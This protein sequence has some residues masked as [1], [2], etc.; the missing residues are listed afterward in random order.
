MYI[1]KRLVSLTLPAQLP[2]AAPDP[3]RTVPDPGEPWGHTAL[4]PIHHQ[5]IPGG[6]VHL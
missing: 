6:S 1:L 5:A 3:H 2:P 4:S